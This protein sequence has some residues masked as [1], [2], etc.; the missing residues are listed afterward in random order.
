M[1]IFIVALGMFRRN[2]MHLDGLNR[3]RVF[4]Q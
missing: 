1:T 2:R 3:L 4:V